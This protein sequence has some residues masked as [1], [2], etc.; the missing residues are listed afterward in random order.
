MSSKESKSE[1]QKEKVLAEE[2]ARVRKDIMTKLAPFIRHQ[3]SPLLM[4]A[5]EFLKANQNSDK[6]WG[7]LRGLPSETKTT[8]LAILA[9][10]LI[11]E[12]SNSKV[13]HKGL[14]FLQ[15]T[16][17]QDGAWSI[18][19]GE[20]SLDI[21]STCYATLSITEAN[22]RK[23]IENSIK[24]IVD[25]Q[26][27]DGGWGVQLSGV[28][29]TSVAIQALTKAEAKLDLQQ[30]AEIYE[31]AIS[32][33][34]RSQYADKGWGLDSKHPSKTVFTAYAIKA[35]SCL[36]SIVPKR[37]P[38]AN[39][40]DKASKYLAKIQNTDG[41]WGEN[42]GE[43]S[44][45]YDTS[46]AILALASVDVNSPVVQNGFRFLVEHRSKDGGWGWRVGETSEVEPTAIVSIVLSLTGEEVVPVS[47]VIS[48]ILSASEETKE[49]EKR[50]DQE[51]EG[52][53]KKTF[54]VR[55]ELE[56][57][58]DKLVNDSDK[59]KDSLLR[60]QKIRQKLEYVR[61][62][63]LKNNAKLG[64]LLS[65]SIISAVVLMLASFSQWYYISSMLFFGGIMTIILISVMTGFY[66]VSQYFSR[67]ERTGPTYVLEIAPIIRKRLA[68]HFDL[69]KRAILTKFI[70]RF[71]EDTAYMSTPKRLRLLAEE[72]KRMQQSERL[73][74]SSDDLDY[75]LFTV[76]WLLK[77][78]YLRYED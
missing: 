32:F 12:D 45:I 20:D 17:K 4:D 74:L 76:E 11:G 26:K 44:N 71:L 78:K 28:M 38:I 41:G 67:R 35:L 56:E 60:E 36:E 2:E 40:I 46:L 16:K 52:R 22:L 30:N 9:L 14:T 75:I 72:L 77:S 3:Q 42:L 59:L 13:I 64:V 69:E 53:V 63:D 15:S 54:E 24:W 48:L 29:E 7:R 49:L 61:E 55:K 58:L 57:R 39:A 34:L 70:A 47:S 6:G 65:A 68:D 27:K 23:A 8:A 66:F 19:P 21:V 33:L 43:L 31:K 5:S 18:R 73:K 50:I 62:R 37:E 10:L 25:N 1:R 51:V